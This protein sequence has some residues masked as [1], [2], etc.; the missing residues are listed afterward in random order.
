MGSLSVA[1]RESLSNI[2][3]LSNWY[4]SKKEETIEKHERHSD[5]RVDGVERCMEAQERA[6]A[7][8]RTRVI[9]RSSVQSL[10]DHRFQQMPDT[11]EP[12]VVPKCDVSP[13]R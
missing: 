2:L 8:H 7:M 1:L 5:T 9:R 4:D 3:R 12:H 13:K 6:G 11:L 10:V